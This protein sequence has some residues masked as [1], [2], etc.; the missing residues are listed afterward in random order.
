MSINKF[1]VFFLSLWM[2]AVA[3][4]YLYGLPAIDGAPAPQWMEQEL[5]VGNLNVEQLGFE[6]SPQ[7]ATFSIELPQPN[8]ATLPL[9]LIAAGGLLFSAQG[10]ERLKR[11]V[12]ARLHFK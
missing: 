1:A 11:F 12:T 2:L 5:P 8:M 9:A 6:L 4:I 3:G 10:G 7:S